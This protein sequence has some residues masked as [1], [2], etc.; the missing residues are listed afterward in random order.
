MPLGKELTKSV[1]RSPL[2]ASDR[3]IPWK[4]SRLM[5]GI[6]PEHDVSAATPAVK[7]ICKSKSV[8]KCGDIRKDCYLLVKRHLSH[9][10]Y[11]LS[12]RDSPISHS[13]GINVC[14]TS[15]NH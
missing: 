2:P 7:L 9:Q 14:Y 15:N 3:H 4:P 5:G 1:L 12:H 13:S 10:T 8:W 6:F 11:G